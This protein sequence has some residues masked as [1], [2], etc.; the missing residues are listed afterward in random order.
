MADNEL[1]GPGFGV[2]EGIAGERAPLLGV[3][4]GESGYNATSRGRGGGDENGHGDGDVEDNANGDD[5]G[6]DDPTEK[7]RIPVTRRRLLA[8]LCALWVGTFLSA[9]DQTLLTTLLPP[10]T[11]EFSSSPTLS[12]LATSYL[13]STAAL[14]PLFGKLTDIF[15][16]RLVLI[17]C[18]MLFLLGTLWCGFSRSATEIV[19]ARVLAGMGGG[20]L[21]T[22]AVMAIS[23]V[24]SLR[25]RGVVQGISNVVFGAGSGLGGV[26]GGWVCD[27]W[28]WR[29]AFWAQ[30]PVIAISAIVVEK[31][32]HLPP[33]AP[34]TPAPEVER[35]VSRLERVDVA[36]SLSLVTALTLLLT[37]LNSGGT[38]VPWS[39]PL[40]GISLVLS[41]A[42]LGLFVYI[43]EKVVKEPILPTALLRKKSVLC[44]C[45]VNWFM[46]MGVYTVLFFLPILHLLLPHPSATLSGLLLSPFS[47]GISLGSLLSGLLLRITSSTHPTAPILLAL[48]T[49][50]SLLFPV[51]YT[52]TTPLTVQLP[53][54]LL[55]GA[56]YGGTLTAMLVSLLATV[57]GK[58]Q[59]VITSASYAFRSAGSVIGVAVAGAVFQNI[60]GKELERELGGKGEEAREWGERVRR[61][62]EEVKEVPDVWRGEVVRALVSALGGVWWFVG[63]VAVLALGCGMGVGR[64]KLGVG[65]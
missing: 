31:V 2:E 42:V 26:F 22:I 11:A 20:G 17:Y 43:E 28:G 29:W 18:N 59:A 45:L 62:L 53:N 10:I 9:L 3:V 57:P 15:T 1:A 32:L 5:G 6:G 47:L 65:R 61:R 36:G 25:D 35:H 55:L 44:A 37:A 48:L 4:A 7:A 52:P 46:V 60:L 40:I 54:L 16:R 38:I 14:Q 64:K 24:V 56:A 23:D 63:G 50:T 30:V 58:M 21:T 13:I 51:L 8:I 12:W 27:T 33:P 41:L 49:T 19:F 34:A 39:H